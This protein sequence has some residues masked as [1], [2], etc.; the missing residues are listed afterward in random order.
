MQPSLQ[1]LADALGIVTKYT[2][3]G[4]NRKDYLTPEHIVKFFAEGFGYKTGSEAEIASSLEKLSRRRWQ[5]AVEGIYVSEQKKVKFDIVLPVPVSVERTELRLKYHQA[6]AEF[7]VPVEVVL[8]G[9]E[10]EIGKSKY[11]RLEINVKADLEVGYYDAMFYIGGKKYKTILAVAPAKCY[12][13]EYL[14]NQKLWGFA[15]QLYSLK[16]EHNWGVGDFTDLKNLIGICGRSGADIIGLNPLNVLSHDYPENSSPYCAVSR[17]FLNPIYIDIE[18]V[19]EYRGED[20]NEVADELAEIKAEKLIDY[21]RIYLLKIKMMEKFYQRFLEDKKS[22]RQSEFKNFLKEQGADLEHLAAFQALYEEKNKTV[23]G[24]WKHWEEEFRNSNNLAVRDY[25]L[26]HEERIGFFKFL[27]FEAS[28]QFDEAHAEISRAGLKVG[29]YRDLAVGVGQD[30]AEFWGNREVFMKEAGAGA[31][32]DAFFTKGQKW[33]LGAFNPFILKEQNYEPFIKVLRANMHNAGALRIDHVMGLMRLYIIPND[34][35]IGTYIMYNFA[36]MLNLVAIESYLN[37]CIVVGESIGVVPEGFLEALERKNVSSLSVLW[38]ERWSEGAGDFKSPYDYPTDAFTSVGTHDMSPLRMWWFG[39]DIAERFRLG[40]ISDVAAR[41]GEYHRRELDRWKLLFALD[42]NGV[43]PEDNLRKGNYIYGEAYP[44]GIEEAV[45][46][47]VA[48]TPCKV[49]LSELENILHVEEF[50]N[51]PGTFREY[52]NWSHRI[53]VDLE[54]L[55]ND[56]AFIRN[57]RAIKK[58]R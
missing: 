56:I 14:E 4:L 12:S 11:T 44:E 37:R 25:I 22:F 38:A 45:N 41:D 24:G 30:S 32:P 13:N 53:P 29:L 43:W 31:P 2:D 20:Y 17:L 10:K 33:C 52:P 49:F 5:K 18:A 21:R 8:T 39:Y 48:R 34:E 27:Q 46:R 16:S 1:K 6:N 28:R 26:S 51:L 40:Q 35:E 42:S 15:I 54:K 19:P 47:F 23:S 50:Q 9:E 55:E 57:V 3:A 58:E 36:D 7:V